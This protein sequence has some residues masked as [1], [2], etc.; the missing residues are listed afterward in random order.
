MR[1]FQFDETFWTDL[2]ER[3]HTNKAAYEGKNCDYDGVF[4]E[5]L[6]KLL[7]MLSIE[8]TEKLKYDYDTYPYYNKKELSFCRYSSFQMPYFEARV[9]WSFDDQENI[10]HVKT[11]KL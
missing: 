10:I 3:I 2:S 5:N 6:T 4:F 7:A 8:N 1:K 9:I 11:I